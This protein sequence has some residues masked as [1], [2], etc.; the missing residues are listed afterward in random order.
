MNHLL[1]I[2]V[3]GA[4]RRVLGL[5]CSAA[6]CQPPVAMMPLKFKYNS[7]NL[8]IIHPPTNLGLQSPGRD[9]PDPGL[10]WELFS[11]NLPKQYRHTSHL[12]TESPIFTTISSLNLFQAS[13]WSYARS[14]CSPG[15]GEIL[16]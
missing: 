9:I 6:S 14:K 15:P 16:I 10:R 4:F 1:Q 8:S 5:H 3:K 12:Q 7:G 2:Q 11:Y 13:L